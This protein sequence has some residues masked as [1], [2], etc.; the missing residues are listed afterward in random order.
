MNRLT[1]NIFSKLSL[2]IFVI[3]NHEQFFS[4]GNLKNVVLSA[5]G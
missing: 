2:K 5:E 1:Q 3:E 4:V